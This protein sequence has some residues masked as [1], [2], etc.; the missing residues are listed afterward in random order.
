MINRI[1]WDIDETLIHTELSEPNQDHVSFSL[2]GRMYYTM[3][4]PCS[5][6]LI[7]F[8]RELVGADQVHILTT[9]TRD[10]AREVNRLAGWGFENSN[11]FSRE[12]LSKYSVR[13]PLAYGASHEECSSHFYAH[14]NN[15]I[16]DNL[17]PRENQNKIAFI[18]INDTYQD[19]YLRI[20]DYYGVEYADS[21]F[22]QEV[23]EFLINR[24]KS[25]AV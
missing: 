3:I 21:N 1:F 7:D 17:R 22:E 15:V 10:Y 16:I 19:N 11:I 23:K 13:F 8:S 9:A 24:N 12:D 4:R 18:G 2:D 5:K 14:K 20:F 25:T 6:A